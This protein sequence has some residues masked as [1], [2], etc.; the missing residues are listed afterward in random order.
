MCDDQ[1]STQLMVLYSIDAFIA[2]LLFFLAILF[3]IVPDPSDLIGILT[4][5]VVH[6]SWNNRAFGFAVAGI[7]FF[8]AFWRSRRIYHSRVITR[9]MQIGFGLL[10]CALILFKIW[11]FTLALGHE[12]RKLAW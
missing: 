3:A 6:F 2:G 11:L 8:V 12:L 7:L 9:P 10:A 4:D 1:N 5:I